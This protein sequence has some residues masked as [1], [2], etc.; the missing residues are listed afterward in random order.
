MDDDATELP[1]KRDVARALLLRGSVFLHLDPRVADVVV[2]GW[3]KAQPQL[4]LQI[5]LDMAVPIVDLRIDDE[6]VCGTL[7]FNRSPFTC[8]VPWSAIFALVGDDGRGMVWPESMPGEIA[9]EIDREVG[10]RAPPAPSAA[11]VD[12]SAERRERAAR[13]RPRR[14]SETRSRDLPPYLRVVK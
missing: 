12:L 4:V 5:G 13:P 3:L 8:W 10:R 2:P 7:S 9:E 14:T 11:V 6:G 1:D